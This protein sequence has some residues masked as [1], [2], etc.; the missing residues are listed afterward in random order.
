MSP[1]ADPVWGADGEEDWVP[2]APGL[3]FSQSV[4]RGLSILEWFTLERP[5]RGSRT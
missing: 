3:R 2:R 1:R 5:V 4:D